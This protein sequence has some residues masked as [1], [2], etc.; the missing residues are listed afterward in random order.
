MSRLSTRLYNDPVPGRACSQCGR[1][2][3]TEEDPCYWCL[4]KEVTA[5][6]GEVASLWEALR[7][8]VEDGDD[9]GYILS[10]RLRELER[11]ARFALERI[12]RHA[13]TGAG[14]DLRQA[15]NRL[16][17]VLDFGTGPE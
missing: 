8:A 6:R 10:K 7:Q 5:L 17:A 4:R 14:E 16:R 12:E 1:Y 11:A 9:Q 2:T 13:G 15:A 3:E